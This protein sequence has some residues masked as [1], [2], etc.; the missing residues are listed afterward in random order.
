MSPPN[1]FV[2]LAQDPVG[3]L[4]WLGYLLFMLA[5]VAAAVPWAVRK[6]AWLLH[7]YQQ[8]RHKRDWWSF[9]DRTDG[10]IPPTWWLGWAFMVIFVLAIAVWALSALVWLVGV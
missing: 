1:P 3:V 9:G 6:S 8:D 5:V 2:E 4:A 10:Y 7:R